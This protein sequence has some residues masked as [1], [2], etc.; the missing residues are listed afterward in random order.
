MLVDTVD[1]CSFYLFIFFY[2]RPYADGIDPGIHARTIF[3]LVFNIG[4]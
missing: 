3:N 4:S 1:K 2:R